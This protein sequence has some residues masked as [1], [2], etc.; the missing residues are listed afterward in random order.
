MEITRERLRRL[1]VF[2]TPSATLCAVYFFYYGSGASWQPFFNVYLRQIGLTGVE[3]GLIASLRTAVTIIGQPLW[4]V[5][6]DVWGRRRTLLITMLLAALMLP[7]LIFQS[8]MWLILAVV[9]AYTILSTPIGP[10]IDSLVLDHIEKHPSS[11]FGRLRLW[12]SAGWAVLAFVAGSAVA[13]HD[14]RLVFAIGTITMLL[15]WVLIWRTRGSDGG[16]TSL[17]RGWSGLGIVLRNRKVLSFLGVVAL[18]QT[19]AAA[20][21]TFYPVYLSE[22]GGS[23]RLIGTAL[24]I[25]GMS[26]VPLFLL[27]ALIIRRWG[28]TRTLIFTFLIFAL[29]SFLYSIITV[30]ELAATVEALHGL[31]FSLYLV[32]AVQYINDRV[33]AEWRATGQALF[34]M[35]NFGI[36]SIIGNTWSGFLYDR[37]GVQQ[38]FMVNGC[39]ILIGAF[40]AAILLRERK[41]VPAA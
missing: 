30:P 35:T 9:V 1:F 3:I 31:S 41:T 25:Q 5:G 37:I 11:S 22:L 8:S 19:G 4:G 29:R 16:V 24:T 28:H 15:G 18:L 36:G 38:M 20:I 13:G 6:A 32:V 7:L 40:A 2:G 12:G 39:V 34:W 27:A 33:P 17:S 23:S 21:F 10:L 14:L 26:E